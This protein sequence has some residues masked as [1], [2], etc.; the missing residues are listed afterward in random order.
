[1]KK[2]KKMMS[3][4]AATLLAVSMTGCGNDDEAR[5]A[6]PTGED[7]NDWDWDKESES[8]YCDDR[9][10]SHFGMFWFAGG[11]FASRSA[12][13]NSSSYKSYKGTDNSGNSYKSGIGSGSRGGFGG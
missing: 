4:V 1:M 12:L 5:P 10:S 6:E 9:S 8:Y 2:T 3:G 7:C 11:W 13:M